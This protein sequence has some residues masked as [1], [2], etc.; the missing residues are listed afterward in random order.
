M[1]LP[2]PACRSFHAEAL[3]Q[4]SYNGTTGT[5]DIT[6]IDGPRSLKADSP[7]ELIEARGKIRQA[8]KEWDAE[9]GDFETVSRYWLYLR[10][11]S[12]ALTPLYRYR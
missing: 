5:I 4:L 6:T 8:I 2:P 12:A 10:H 7:R 1:I 3:P 9:I 11:G